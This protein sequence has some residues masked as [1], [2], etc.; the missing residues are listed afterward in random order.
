APRDR[1]QCIDPGG[2]PNPT[3]V[4]I[5]MHVLQLL[6]RADRSAASAL[7]DALARVIDQDRVWVYYREAPL[8]PIL[9]QGDLAQAG[10]ALAIPERR[11]RPPVPGQEAW[12][13]AAALVRRL[14]RA[15][16]PASEEILAVLRSLAAD[17]FSAARRNPPLLYHNDLSASVPR[18]YWSEDFGYA[19]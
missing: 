3:D 1:Y 17:G 6:A 5:Q 2:D 8:V 19:L 18:F 11:L 9:R 12:L 4:A 10:C 16:P 14:G 13:P 7:C 15:A